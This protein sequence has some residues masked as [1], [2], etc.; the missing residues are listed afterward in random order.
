MF[1][2]SFVVTRTFRNSK[3][4]NVCAPLFSRIA[5]KGPIPGQ[6]MWRLLPK[7]RKER[8]GALK[9][10]PLWKGLFKKLWEILSWKKLSPEVR[11]MDTFA[12]DHFF[13]SFD[14]TQTWRSTSL[15]KFTA[16]GMSYPKGDTN[17]ERGSHF[18]SMGT[19]TGTLSKP[20]AFLRKLLFYLVVLTLLFCFVLSVYSIR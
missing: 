10:F 11:E 4:R 19:R 12:L 13:S 14:H 6:S 3:D 17:L 7:K 18:N 20:Q 9:L 1:C 8:L 2:M 15:S 16:L 5:V